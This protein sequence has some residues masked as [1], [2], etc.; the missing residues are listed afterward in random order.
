[1]RQIPKHILWQGQSLKKS[2]SSVVQPFKN[3]LFCAV[4]YYY[5]RNVVAVLHQLCVQSYIVFLLLYL[6]FALGLLHE[7]DLDTLVEEMSSVSE[8]W[9][10]IGQKLFNPLHDDYLTHNTSCST[11]HDYM[12]EMLK[13]WLQKYK[14][15]TWRN[16]IVSLKNV[17]ER[18]LADHLKAKYYPGELTTTTSSQFSLE[19]HDGED[20]MK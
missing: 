6:Q 18:Q 1:M 13:I 8:K 17:Q 14:T 4:M 16:I 19:S 20:E 11:S 2:T 7:Y 3:A 15:T 9:K 10:A 12:R 5:V